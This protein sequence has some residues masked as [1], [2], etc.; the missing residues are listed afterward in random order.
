MEGWRVTIQVVE[1][2]SYAGCL[3]EELSR[4]TAD[5]GANL[6]MMPSGRCSSHVH[7]GA[8]LRQILSVGTP[9]GNLEELVD[10]AGE[11]GACH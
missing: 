10:V 8:D 3:G 9:E 6:A 1:M 11:R 4:A 7:L 5:G 2:S